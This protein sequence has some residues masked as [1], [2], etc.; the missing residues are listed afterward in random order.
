MYK[1]VLF[2]PTETSKNV[3]NCTQ[4]NGF[5]L[6]IIVFPCYKFPYNLF[7]FKQFTFIKFKNKYCFLKNLMNSSYDEH[8]L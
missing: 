5:I 6:M 7:T 2:T 3:Q 8:V 1:I 4:L